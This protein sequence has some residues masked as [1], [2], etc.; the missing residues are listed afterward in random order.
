MPFRG[1]L[2]GEPRASFRRLLVRSLAVA[3]VTAP[4]AAPAVAQMLVG[5]GSVECGGMYVISGGDTLSKVSERAYGDSML[6]GISPTQTGMR[7][8]AIRS[9]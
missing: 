1:L 3:L 6:Y 7:W 9:T 2:S 5:D 4:V 8:A